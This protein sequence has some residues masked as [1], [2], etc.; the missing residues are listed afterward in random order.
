[1]QVYMSHVHDT[2]MIH[3]LIDMC[4]YL[5]RWIPIHRYIY[6]YTYIYNNMSIYRYIYVY[7]Y[8]YQSMQVSISPYL[9]IYIHMDIYMIYV[10]LDSDGRAAARQA[11]ITTRSCGMHAH[12]YIYIYIYVHTHAC[13]AMLCHACMHVAPCHSMLFSF[14]W[15]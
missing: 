8:I 7:P 2:R 10:F 13:G 15:G 9:H 3:K 5:H 6:I 11:K 1:M 14:T 4:V 12:V